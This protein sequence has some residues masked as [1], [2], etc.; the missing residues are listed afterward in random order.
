MCRFLP[1]AEIPFDIFTKFQPNISELFDIF[2]IISFFDDF[3]KSREQIGN[4]STKFKPY[5]FDILEILSFLMI[6]KTKEIKLATLLFRFLPD[7][8]V[9]IDIF[10]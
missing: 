4:L 8:E 1:D 10:T 5:I 7:A 3:L 2:E 6:F 9:P